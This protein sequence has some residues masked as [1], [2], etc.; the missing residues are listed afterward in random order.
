MKISS[1]IARRDF[2]KSTALIT[3]GTIGLSM[4]PNTSHGTELFAGERDNIIGPIEGFSPQV[5]TL[6]SMMTWMRRVILTPVK[7]MTIEQL[8]YVHDGNS[9]S[10]GAMLLHLAA[11]ERYYQI[12]TFEGKRWGDWNEKDK[13]RFDIAMNL[14]DKARKTIKG[15]NLAFYLS[16]LKEV[17]E[18]TI[19]EFKKRDDKWILFVDENWPWGPTNNYCKWFHVCEHESNHN[20]QIKYI[21]SRLPGA[22]QSKD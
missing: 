22:K 15:N 5:G 19:K 2:I 13:N 11:M 18:N 7:D 12:H 3:S 8:D 20:G 10:I 6:L 21:K 4:I 14:G 16:T 17:R 1:P 9:N